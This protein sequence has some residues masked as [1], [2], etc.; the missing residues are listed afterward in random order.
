MT[1]LD[2]ARSAIKNA[3]IENVEVSYD[4]VSSFINVLILASSAI[5]NSEF[6]LSI[7]AQIYTNSL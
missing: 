1:N 6:W 4:L 7:M 2:V 3:Y 5:I